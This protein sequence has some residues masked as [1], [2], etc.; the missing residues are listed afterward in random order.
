MAENIQKIKVL[1]LYSS[2]GPGGAEITMLSLAY[3]LNK[4]GIENIIAC[5]TKSYLYS[6]AKKLNL[7]TIPL[8]IRGSLDP[9][10]IFCLIKLVMKEKPEIIH[11]H[12]GKIFWP[13]IFIKWIFK[14]KPKL[15]FHRHLD[16]R[17]SSFSK[18]HYNYADMIIATS[19]KVS[20]GL[21]KYEKVKPLKIV[22]IYNGVEIE[23]DKLKVE[24]VRTKYNLKDKI[25]IGTAGA[26]NKPEG[27]GQRYL[28]EVAEILRK[29]FNNLHYLIVG[30]GNLKKE[31]EEYAKRIKVADIVTF[32]GFVENIYDYLEAM[33]IFCALS[34]GTEAFSRVIVE[35]QLIGKPVIATN[36]GGIP[37]TFINSKTG[38]LIPPRDI[39][40]LKN[41]LINLIEN[42]QERKKMGIA[43]R[44]W[45]EEKFNI[46]NWCVSVKSVYY[47][48]LKQ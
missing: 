5:P 12:Q 28:I 32:T 20:N 18:S 38:F 31:L 34:V 13:A 33:D 8:R 21:I 37:E 4:E 45:A 48:L 43:G 7:K 11:V 47:S 35:A 25:V 23:E 2:Y 39:A 30:D 40:A 3:N 42:E 44:K 19:R 24:D 16:I 15:V 14:N 6:K 29:K 17:S 46:K 9:I 41:T 36:I 22:I 27:K 1:H 26:I 10:G